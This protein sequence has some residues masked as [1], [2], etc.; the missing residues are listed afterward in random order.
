MLFGKGLKKPLTIPSGIIL[1]N[2]TK[3]GSRGVNL[4]ALPASKTSASRIKSCCFFDKILI[5]SI[6]ELKLD[7][8]PIV[9]NIKAV[10]VI[11]D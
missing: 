9:I 7:N 3:F 11:I 2:E 10:K 4:I 5:G 6:L 1:K 8:I